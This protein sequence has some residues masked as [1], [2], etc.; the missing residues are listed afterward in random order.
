MQI[1]TIN[2]ATENKICSYSLF[3]SVK[4]DNALKKSEKAF[5]KWKNV[6]VNERAGFI[7]GIG[8]SLSKNK[9]NLAKTITEEMGKP[10][11]ESILEI[12]KCAWLCS[13]FSKNAAEFLDKEKVKTEYRK[14]YV[15]FDPLGRI[16]G[17]MPWNF[18]FWQVFRFAVP[19][20]CAGNSVI[21]KHSTITT[22]C[23]LK[24]EK[25]F[26]ENIS[27]GIFQSVITDSTGIENLIPK[28]DGVSLTG[29]VETGRKIGALAGKNIKKIVLELGGS[30]PF[31]VLK[32]ADLNSAC[33]SAVKARTMNSGQSCIAAKRFIVVKEKFDEFSENIIKIISGLKV[34]DPADKK[35]DIGPMA[36]SDLVLKLEKQVEK[37]VKSGAKILYRGNEKFSR[38]F[39]FNPVVLSADKKSI[40][41]ETFGPLFEIIKVKDNIAA[42]KEANNTNFGL[43]ASLWTN[44]IKRAEKY[45][46]DIDTGV[47]FVNDTVKSDPRLPFGGVKDSGLGRELSRYGLLEFCNIKTVVVR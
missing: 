34:G 36:R 39:Y 45:A 18:P 28:V 3:S 1:C 41:E 15:R 5:Q 44:N 7:A 26:E 33:I 35:T 37:A 43:G 21:L 14:S 40:G 10:V 4:I 8:R 27:R 6:N 16:L 22:G 9:I 32:D 20:L 19:S 29:S 12:E 17:I 25:I 13:Y 47:V 42:L 23:S 2:P 38:G 46:G 30:D 11:K 24:I 31:I